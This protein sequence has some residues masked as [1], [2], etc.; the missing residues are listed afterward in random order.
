MSPSPS[1][2]PAEAPA[3]PEEGWRKR[4]HAIIYEAD[5]PAGRAFDIVLLL[6][7]VLSV[8]FVALET[9]EGLPVWMNTVLWI[10]EWVVTVLFTIEYILRLIV[11]KRPLRYALS[12]YGLVDL[13]ST[14]PTWIAF[15]VPGLQALLTIRSIRL[16]RIF[17]ILKM[18]RMVQEMGELRHAFYAARAKMLV[19]LYAVTIMVVIL[20]ALMYLV[21]GGPDSNFKSIPDSMYWTVVTMTTVGYGDITPVTALGKGLAVIMML[22]GY[23]IIVVPTGILSVEVSRAG[24]SMNTQHCD[25]CGMDEHL[26]EARYCHRCGSKL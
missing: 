23:S 15:F 5:T 17:R 24:R 26:D 3:N 11:I 7:I 10:G 22:L 1:P 12:F 14:L 4:L 20:S 13:F 2:Q 19:F 21:E 9:V 25:Q 16:F 18:G 8:V 6:F